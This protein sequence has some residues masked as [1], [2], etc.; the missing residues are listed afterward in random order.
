M[1][2][3]ALNADTDTDYAAPRTQFD[4]KPLLLIPL[5][6]L[7]GLAMVQ[8][9][10]TWIMLTFS[11]IATGMIFF[12]VSSGLTLVFGLMGVMNFGHSIFITLG[13]IIGGM[14][15]LPTMLPLVACWFRGDNLILNLLAMAVA[16]I[17][18]MGATALAAFVFERL[19]VRHAYDAPLTTQIM[20]TVGGM[21]V[22]EQLVKMHIGRGMLIRRP[23]S[24][25]GS[26]LFG[27]I[28]IQK[29]LLL[30]L[31]VGAIILFLMLR[32]LNRTKLGLLVRAAVEQR[33]MV[34]AM[35]YKVK[36]L[37][38]GLFM[39]GAALAALGGLLYGA[40]QGGAG[41]R[42][43]ADMM[44][45]IFMVLIIG[46]LG[47]IPGACIAAILVGLLT[48]YVGFVFPPLTAFSTI[49]LM[50]A[51]ALWRPQGLYP[52]RAG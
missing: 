52:V 31:A 18:A 21:V 17:A 19:I 35:G 2:A 29:Y 34:E 30:V 39:A 37:F 13:A 36:R 27:D 33:D 40:Y 24:L 43:G 9:T 26:F 11:G 6:A 3:L 46:G 20:L 25:S 14:M 41:M 48:N 38:L 49:F 28:V 10:S 45:P 16:A 15:L 47:S 51:V 12:M 32:T 42:F 1:Q 7:L 4:I 44:I 5:L 8:N 23:A 50:F 22:L